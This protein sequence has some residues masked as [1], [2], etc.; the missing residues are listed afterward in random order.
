MLSMVNNN[1]SEPKTI[2]FKNDYTTSSTTV[3]LG[4]TYAAVAGGNALYNC[5]VKYDNTTYNYPTD[6]TWVHVGGVYYFTPKV[7][8][9]V[10]WSLTAGS[11]QSGNRG[12]FALIQIN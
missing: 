5:W 12:S 8:T 1:N 7:S 2:F 3:E 6:G 9:T 11:Q 10:S 4:K